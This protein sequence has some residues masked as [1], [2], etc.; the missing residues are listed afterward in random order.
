[1]KV[2]LSYVC[3][4]PPSISQAYNMCCEQL[5]YLGIISMTHYMQLPTCSFKL[6]CHG[7]FTWLS[8]MWVK[9]TNLTKDVCVC[10]CV[11]W[12]TLCQ[13]EFLFLIEICA[14]EGH[15][16]ILEYYVRTYIWFTLKL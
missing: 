10:V 4:Q 8:Q 13:I 9:S 6:V 1:M 7:C 15:S 2:A 14:W 3:T 11:L 12:M 16:P 5:A